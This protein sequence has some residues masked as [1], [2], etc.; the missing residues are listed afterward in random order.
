MKAALCRWLCLSGLTLHLGC[1]SAWPVGGPWACSDGGVCAEGLTC[2]DGVCCKPDGEP[3]CP[4]LPFENT[5]SFGSK[6]ATYFRDNDADGAG[7]SSTG[8]IFCRAPIKELWV[9]DSKD[10][11]DADPAVGPLAT[12]RCNG[13]DDDCDGDVDEGL[14]RQ[15]WYRDTDG[16]GFGEDC[17]AC[18]LLACAQPRGYAARA[19]DCEP[20][21]AAVFPGAPELCNRR[22]DNCNGQLDDAPF[23]DVENP[24]TLGQTFDCDTGQQGLCR[25][26]G[27]QCL[28]SAA[29]SQFESVCV[30][31]A[32][33]TTDV[34]NDALDNDCSGTADDRPGCRGP[35]S[36]LTAPG[37][38]FGAL[39]FYDAGMP[40]LPPLPS[41]CMKNQAGGAAMAWLNPSWIGTGSGL[42]LWYAE[43]PAGTWW[44]LS[45]AS[46]LRLPVTSSAVGN[47]GA[48][49]DTPGRFE[50]AVI[51][52]CGDTDTAFQR[53]TP[54]TPAQ[55]FK[56]SAQTVRVPLRPVADDGWAASN[57]SFDLSRVRRI[58]VLL[59][60][61]T[62]GNT[63]FTNRF[64]TDA[65][66]VGFE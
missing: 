48:V 45:R 43:A 46:A 58:E 12:E 16:D 1:F 17:D 33:A 26:G 36:L 38:T 4:T 55:H 27:M 49:W 50:N 3:R 40:T 53:Y 31:R 64:L 37:I 60:P 11:D 57:P 18:R 32:Q 56:V 39:T 61:A 10:C 9:E 14:A 8:R 6:P 42:H 7:A 51:H 65:G 66:I 62:A 21:N 29:S 59:A 44:D 5:C 41:R 23:V 28:F 19:G 13:Q 30:A 54:A 2:D 24:G 34:C 52:L 63:T 22:D 25:P 47:L 15:L 35:A 20:M